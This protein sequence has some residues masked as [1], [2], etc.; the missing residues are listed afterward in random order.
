M[1]L[2]VPISWPAMREEI[3]E[4]QGIRAI[5]YKALRMAGY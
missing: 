1:A 5:S 3:P 4:C 2:R